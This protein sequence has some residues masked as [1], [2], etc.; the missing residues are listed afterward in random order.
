[1]NT[2][3]S[4]VAVITGAASG[5]GYAM[6]ERF[7]REGARLVLADVD[8]AALENAAGTLSANGAEV[9]AVPTN[10]SKLADVEALAD[11]AAARFGNVH[12]LCN[13]AGVGHMG[14]LA[15]S[16]IQDWEWLIGVNLWGVIYGVHTFFPRM[17]KHGEEGHIV[18]TASIAGLIC[19]PG[20]GIYALTK[21]AVVSLSETLYHESRLMQ[22]KIGVSVLCPGWVKT[23]IVDSKRNRP[24]ELTNPDETKSPLAQIAEELTRQVVDSGIPP[25]AVADRVIDAIRT[26]QFYIHTHPEMMHAVN[27]R[28]DGILNGTAPSFVPPPGFEL[29]AG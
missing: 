29:I 14:L 24:V 1:M 20:M 23:R 19:G 2:L 8:A 22:S 7:A 16:T 13:N 11:A 28:V 9:L 6:A 3:H 27:L 26:G 10:V 18:N 25:Q 17:L 4:K 12:V 5:I 21:H 15:E